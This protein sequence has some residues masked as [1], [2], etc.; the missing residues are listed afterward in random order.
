VQEFLHTLSAARVLPPADVYTMLRQH[1]ERGQFLQEILRG[2]AED[3]WE[4]PSVER[5]EEVQRLFYH[6]PI[7]HKWFQQFVGF[8]L[9]MGT[10]PK[11]WSFLDTLR[12]EGR[13]HYP[14]WLHLLLEA[15]EGL[16]KRRLSQAVRADVRAALERA[17]Q[18]H[19]LPSWQEERIRSVLEAMD[20]DGTHPPGEPFTGSHFFH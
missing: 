5:W 6:A 8:R 18:S 7:S 15:V 11:F 12:Q 4:S 3:F 1:E 13:P 16:E 2:M 17:L 20:V 19:T 9:E 14:G 10:H